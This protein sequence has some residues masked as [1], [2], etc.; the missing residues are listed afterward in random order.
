[1]TKK[2]Y[3]LLSVSLLI[4]IAIIGFSAKPGNSDHK[5][6]LL[7]ES[8]AFQVPGGWGYNILVDHKIFIHQEIIPAIQG[9]SAFASKID[10]E[11]IA[12]LIVH[13]ITSKQLP[14]VTIKELDSL[15][16]NY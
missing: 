10:A 9:N 7:V 2:S 4:V 15:Q 11:K 8:S 1:M 16:I 14:S 3:I 13:K 5:N 6:M 12:N